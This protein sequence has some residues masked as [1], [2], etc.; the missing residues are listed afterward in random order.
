MAALAQRDLGHARTLINR[1]GVNRVDRACKSARFVVSGLEVIVVMQNKKGA[2]T[3][4][5][6]PST[7]SPRAFYRPCD[8]QPTPSCGEESSPTRDSPRH[9]MD[10]AR[11]FVEMFRWSIIA[12]RQKRSEVRWR[13][14][15]TRHPSDVEIT[16]MF[17]RPGVTGLAVIAGPISGDLVVRDFDDENSYARWADEHQ[18]LAVRLPTVRTKRGY[19]V[20]VRIPGFNRIVHLPDGEFRGSGYTLLPP[21]PHPDGI[22]Y[23]W[24]IPPSHDILRVEAVVFG[25]LSESSQRKRNG[26]NLNAPQA[27]NAPQG[28]DVTH[29]MGPT[30]DWSVVDEIIS[31]TL[32][33]GPGQRNRK[34]FQLAR[35]LRAI[36]PLNTDHEFLRQIVQRW[37][38]FALPVIRTK[39]FEESWTDFVIAW[40]AVL[41]PKGSSWPEIV[42]RARS[43]LLPQVER[44]Y[45]TNPAIRNLIALCSELQAAAGDQPFFLSARKAEEALGVPRMTVWRYLRRLQFDGIL[46]LIELGTERNHKASTYRYHGRD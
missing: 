12:T 28:T 42:Q 20:Y 11:H 3:T 4:R 23:K 39:D 35:E 15:Q 8:W 7:L 26:Q 30:F 40:Q 32:P 43:K 44:Q 9:I 18:S 46:E 27:S 45:S 14:F 19:H 16:E 25:A 36:L 5:Q 24:L 29:C 17:R 13:E 34:L 6:A 1:S 10:L 33:N 22:R 41:L 37:F 2:G 31:R 21:S 38:E